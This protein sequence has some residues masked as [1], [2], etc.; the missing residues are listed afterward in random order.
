MTLRELLAAATPGPW[1]V[2]G[3][4][5]C[6]DANP[7]AENYVVEEVAELSSDAR[8]PTDADALLIVAAVNRLPLLLN[9]QDVARETHGHGPTG[10]APRVHDCW[11]CAALSAL[12]KADNE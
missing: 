10:H 9:L 7:N 6:S 1:H 12:D 3:N 2:E 8:V 5:I 11:I 4:S